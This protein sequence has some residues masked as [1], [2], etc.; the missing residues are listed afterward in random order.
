M[1]M[2]MCRS[3]GTFVRARMDGEK[4]KPVKAECPECGNTT[5]Q[6]IHEDRVVE[7]DDE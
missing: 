7:P 2:V 1:E 6:D 3:C 5:F 4:R